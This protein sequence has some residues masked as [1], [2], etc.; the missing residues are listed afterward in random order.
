MAGSASEAI[1]RAVSE[2]L[3]V[4]LV[5]RDVRRFPDGEMQVELVDPVRG[6]DVFILQATSPPVEAHAMELLLL[7]DAC[8]RGGARKLIGVIPYLGYARQDRRAG[9]KSLGARVAADLITTGRFERLM[10]I[11]VH[12][13]AIEGFFNI[14][15]EHLTAAP[16][17]AH[18]V[19]RHL[20]PHSIIVAPDFGAV[21][22]ARAYARLLG[23]PIAFVQ[24]T[25]LNGEAV[26]AQGVVGEVRGRAPLIVDDMLST[27]GTLVAAVEALRA[28][29]AVDPFVV[30]VTHALLVARARDLLRSL[31]LS[32]VATTDTVTIDPAEPSIAVTSV[33]PLLAAAIRRTHRHQSLLDLDA[34]TFNTAGG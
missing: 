6:R 32:W 3:G 19:A 5:G 31:G 12:T 14:P 30:A 22:L 1:G 28:A 29:G 10:A 7:A 27:G 20:R 25:R 16:T 34:V 13:P 4:P 2:V 11:D 33:A 15:I 18:A 8:R 9:D 21:K 23:F 26:A 17:L 24:K